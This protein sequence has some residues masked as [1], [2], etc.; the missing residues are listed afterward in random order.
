VQDI[1]EIFSGLL[2]TE[3]ALSL[4]FTFMGYKNGGLL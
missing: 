3:R 4:G 2:K 1:L